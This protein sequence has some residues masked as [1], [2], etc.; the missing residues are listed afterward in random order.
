MMVKV[1]KSNSDYSTTL[2]TYPRDTLWSESAVERCINLDGCVSQ[3]G[4]IVKLCTDGDV[5]TQTY[6][7]M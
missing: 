6:I 5:N 4:I 7:Y 1:I 2:L 3:S